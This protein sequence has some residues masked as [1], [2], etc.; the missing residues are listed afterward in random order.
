[1]YRATTIPGNFPKTDRSS[2]GWYNLNSAT[3]FANVSTVGFFGLHGHYADVNMSNLDIFGL[4]NYRYDGKI[5]GAGIS[6]GYHWIL[7][8]RWSMEATIGAGY[9]RLD[10]DKYACGKCGEK[11]GHNNKNYF[12]PTKVGLSIIYTIK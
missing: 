8:N 10:Y 6:Y 3:G 1:M 4:G 12:G 5:Y 2:T 11:L 7:K 9:A